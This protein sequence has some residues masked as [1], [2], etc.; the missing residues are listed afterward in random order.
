MGD[1][2]RLR[3]NR[4]ARLSDHVGQRTLRVHGQQAEDLPP[5]VIGLERLGDERVGPT[6]V[7]LTTLF[8]FGVGRQHE[9]RRALGRG[10][11]SKLIQNLPP[12]HLRQADVQHEQ[13]RGFIE[14]GFEAR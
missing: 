7:R 13:V 10:I 6:L 12:I 1:G 4:S 9:H 11:G 8:L 14:R 3:A 5:E 2:Q